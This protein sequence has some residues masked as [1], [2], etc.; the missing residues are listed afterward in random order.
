MILSNDLLFSVDCVNYLSQN[1]RHAILQGLVC[2]CPVIGQ[3]ENTHTHKKRFWR[4]VVRLTIQISPFKAR[5]HPLFHWVTR[6]LCQLLH[7]DATSSLRVSISWLI[8]KFGGKESSTVKPRLTSRNML[9]FWFYPLLNMNSEDLKIE[10]H[11]LQSRTDLL[12]S[13]VELINREWPKSRE[14]RWKLVSS[15]QMHAVICIPLDCHL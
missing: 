11:R 9:I 10:V 12:E 4:N 14:H 13:T 8:K 2:K 3:Q 6:C 1:A 7:L 15:F 5:R